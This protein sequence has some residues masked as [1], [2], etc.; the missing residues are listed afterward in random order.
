VKETSIDGYVIEIP[1]NHLTATL[2]VNKI[3]PKFVFQYFNL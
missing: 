1:H 2:E 3:L